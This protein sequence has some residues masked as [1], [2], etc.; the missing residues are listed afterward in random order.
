M[1]ANE[2]LECGSAQVF[3]FRVRM[4]GNKSY[5]PAGRF[6]N[7]NFDAGKHY[8]MPNG[9]VIVCVCASFSA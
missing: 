1:R 4:D 3:V 2:L 8:G 9:G 6:G 5:A 7:V